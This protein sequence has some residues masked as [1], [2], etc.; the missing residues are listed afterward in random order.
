[1]PNS[2][3][4]RGQVR[5]INAHHTDGEE[6][7]RIFASVAPKLAVFSHYNVAP[8]SALPLVRQNYSGPLE[9]GEDLMTIDIGDAV[10]VRRF[11]IPRS[12]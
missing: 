5:A 10:T 1:M 8:A 11:T 7:G 4:T 3:Q 6:A 12:K 2:R 9:F